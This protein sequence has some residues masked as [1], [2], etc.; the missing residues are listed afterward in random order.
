MEEIR[1][2]FGHNWRG[3]QDVLERRVRLYQM[4]TDGVPMDQIAVAIGVSP[5]QCWYD[6]VWIKKKLARATLP[7]LVEIRQRVLDRKERLWT[8][9]MSQIAAQMRA[10]PDDPTKQARPVNPHLIRVA[11]EIL[12]GI[13]EIG[14]V[15][16]PQVTTHEVDSPLVTYLRALAGGRVVVSVPDGGNGSGGSPAGAPAPQGD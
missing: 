14:G 9:T 1:G 6:W 3:R 11:N 10:K 12:D 8:I 16:A 5:R 15:R 13:A 7:S 4:K 2:V